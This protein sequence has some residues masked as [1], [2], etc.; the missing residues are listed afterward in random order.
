MLDTK[1]L[2]NN[3]ST[4]QNAVPLKYLIQTLENEYNK[5]SNITI[6]EYV[7]LKNNRSTIYYK[8]PSMRVRDLYYDVVFEFDTKENEDKIK[9]TTKFKVYCNSPSFYF[10]YANLFRRNGSLLFPQKYPSMMELDPETRNPDQV[11][12]FDKYVYT[13]LRLSMINPLSKMKEEM[14]SKSKP[15]I[16]SFNEKRFEYIKKVK[17]EKADKETKARGL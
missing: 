10:R 11:V 5:L 7:D 2:L 8:S 12:T 13:C 17:L 16:A 4:G 1:T 3:L 9:T 15:K 6:L 14:V